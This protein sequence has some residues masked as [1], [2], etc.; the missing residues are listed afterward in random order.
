MRSLTSLTESESDSESARESFRVGFIFFKIFKVFFM[1][2]GLSK[3]PCYT[4]IC[5]RKSIYVVVFQLV[6][7]IEF[8][9]KPERLVLSESGV[10]TVISSSY[11]CA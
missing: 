11:F 4:F 6:F 2:S 1:C 3:G 9:V 10:L 7:C 5:C 8:S